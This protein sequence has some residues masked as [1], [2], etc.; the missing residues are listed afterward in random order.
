VCPPNGEQVT[1]TIQG[2]PPVVATINDNTGDFTTSYSTNTIPVGTYPVTYSY[3]TSGSDSNFTSAAGTGQPLTVTAA[4]PV[5]T[6][7]ATK[8]SS[9]T[10]GTA[11]VTVSGTICVQ[12]SGPCPPKNEPVT[13]TIQGQPPVVA[14]IND[15]TGDFSVSYPTN[16]IKVGTYTVT[17]SYTSD[18]NFNSAGP[19]MGQS[20]TVNPATTMTVLSA[21]PQNGSVY[22]QPVSFTATVTVTSPGGGSPGGTVEF[23]DSVTGKDIP[24]C[25][26]VTLV[27]LQNGS[28]AT[29]TTTMLAVNSNH[30]IT[31]IYA[32]NAND[33]NSSGFISP[34]PVNKANTSVS[35]FTSSPPSSSYLQLVTFTA[36]VSVVSPGG[37]SPPGT[38]DFTDI[39]NPQSPVTLCSKVP[40]SGGQAQCAPSPSPFS[41]GSHSIQA[42][43]NNTD[44]NYNASNA[45]LTQVVAKANTT[46]TLVSAI[47]P[48]D[49]NQFVLF[50]ATISG[51]YG[52]APTGTVDFKDA[53]NTPPV[54]ICSAVQLMNQ[55]ATCNTQMLGAGTHTIVAMYNGDP[56]FNSSNGSLQQMVGLTPTTTTASTSLNPSV[57]Q[58]MVTF[59]IT[60]RPQFHNSTSPGGSVTFTDT[61]SSPAT[62]V[63]GCAPVSVTNG[64]ATCS[65]TGLQSGV[66]SLTASYSGDSNFQS[67]SATL[68]QTVEDFSPGV[69]WVPQVTPMAV[70][71]AQGYTNT[72]Q[73]FSPQTITYSVTPLYGYNNALALTCNVTPVGPGCIPATNAISFVGGMATTTVTIDASKSPPVGT[74]T[75]TITA[76]DATG[77]TLAHNTTFTVLITNTVPAI[78]LTPGSAGSQTTVSFVAPVQTNVTFSCP[79]ILPAVK[80]IS[81]SFNPGTATVSPGSPTAIQVTVT[82]ATQSARLNTPNR[83][84]AALWLGIPAIVMFGSLPCGRLSRKKLLQLLG[85]MLVVVALLQGIGCGGGFVRPPTLATPGGSYNLQVVGMD[86]NNVVQTSAT[87]PVNILSAQ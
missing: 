31:A 56:S 83:I 69:D 84:L 8:P 39:T 9:I 40:L 50:T 36:T 82:A 65:T 72:G 12:P 17:Y 6:N 32:G 77:L 3:N 85:L 78:N 64:Q 54:P 7:L 35:P 59:S 86:S 13:I 16:A 81:C 33:G 66:R 63:P 23:T 52:G 22:L 5:F 37:G 55:Q 71:V 67:S 57:S 10:Y 34:Y 26:A 4:T 30:T 73:I 49:V 48:S 61:T 75:V 47:N 2:Q 70:S 45:T 79:Q 62:N 25:S 58:Q 21:N 38:V 46:T 53:T 41:V 27:T 24:G 44:G 74:Y 80:G 28:A 19:S 20:L 29:C 43:Y 87:I 15:N 60:V 1:I 11:S 42:T 51:Q 76:M 14:T 68:T 18:G